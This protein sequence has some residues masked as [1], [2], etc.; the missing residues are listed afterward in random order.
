MGLSSSS[1]L[2]DA[3]A[4]YS[5]NLSY[6]DGA[7][8]VSQARLFR[9][10]CRWL[11]ANLPRQSGGPTVSTQMSPDLI[12]KE[13]ENVTRWLDGHD[14]TVNPNPGVTAIGFNEVRT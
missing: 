6:D 8:S 9:A 2:T 12:A 11:L 7:G 1:T 3:W 13:L 4:Q 10:A 5:D 14:T